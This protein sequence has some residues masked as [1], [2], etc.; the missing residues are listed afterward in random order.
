[1]ARNT[2]TPAPGAT[3]EREKSR[4]IGELRALWPFLKPRKL[5]ILAALAALTFTASIS[6]TLPLAVRRVVDNFRTGDLELL[7]RYFMAALGI[8]L[9]MALGTGLRY[10]LVTRLG[11]R[12]GLYCH[13]GHFGG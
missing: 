2:A 10:A 8:A 9:M 4:R 11:E 3:E 7:D 6:L 12:V 1:M 13:C 5:L